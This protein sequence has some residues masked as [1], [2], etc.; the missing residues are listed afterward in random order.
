MRLFLTLST[1]FVVLL[2]QGQNKQL[3]YNVDNLPQTLMSNPGAHINFDAHF[4]IP[5]FSH[6]NISAGSSGV[7]LHDIFDDSNPNV[8]QRVTNTINRLSS[9]DYFTAREQIE[10]LSLGWRL[11]KDDYFSAG[12]YQEMDLFAYFP[13]DPA[14]LVSQG[15]ANYIN[16]PFDFSHVSFTGEVLTVYHL[17]LNRIIDHKLTVGAR[18]KMYSGI[19]NVE[20]VNNT[21]IFLT[22]NTPNGPNYY[23][24]FA[25]NIDVRVNT[26]GFTTL[27]DANQTVQEASR[28]LLSKSFFGGNIGAGVDLGATY[29]IRDNLIL[30]GS[31]QDLGLMFQRDDVENYTYKGT[32]QTDGIEPLFPEIGLDGTALPYWD[33]FEDEVDRNLVDKTL[34]ESYVTW[35][36]FQLN[37][38]L[39]FGFGENCPPCDYRIRTQK[40]YQ[41]KVG[42]QVF[43]IKRP[44]ALKYAL[45]TYYDTMVIPKLRIKIAYTLDDFSYTN[46][47]L[48]V[49]TRLKKFNFYLAADNLFGYINLAK[50]H[51]QSVQLGFQFILNK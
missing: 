41:N 2:C 37:A 51:Y 18:L 43:G 40:I 6:I 44:G 16:I 20:S 32:Y 13:K 48:L 50:S 42:I 17:G 45:S 36:P 24:H 27:R 1:F 19:F 30:T 28:D 33:E 5:L 14:V 21:G 38:S 26:S 29:K 39:Q 47:G 12:I 11:N 35:R 3:L 9:K 15:N 46:V 7:N 31:V 49:S 34:N 4:G 22:R 8:N 25:E 23:R 10:I